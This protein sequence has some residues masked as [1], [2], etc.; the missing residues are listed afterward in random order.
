[1]SH[2]FD[3]GQKQKK[4]KNNCKT[5]T[6]PPPTGRRLRKIALYKS[7]YYYYYYYKQLT[8]TYSTTTTA[9]QRRNQGESGESRSLVIICSF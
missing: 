5:Y 6:H 2:I 7:H 4:T 3:R 1:L 9:K 8:M